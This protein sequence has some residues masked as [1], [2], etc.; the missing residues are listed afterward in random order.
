MKTEKLNTK[1]V[2]PEIVC[3]YPNLAEP[4]DEEY[5]GKYALSIPAPKSDK[6]FI[7]AINTA[8]SN[9]AVNVWGE[10]YKDLRGVKTYLVDCD[11]DP[12][13]DDDEM[14]KGCMKFSVKGKRQPGLV[15]QDGKT[16]CKQ[17]DIEDTFYP[18]A[19]I[20]VSFSAYATE[21]GGSKL[22]AFGINNVMFVKEGNRIGGGASAS[23]DFDGLG[24]DLFPED[25]DA[26]MFT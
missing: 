13:F 4:A 24:T 2:T 5:G 23:S 1:V 20:R 21:T 18:G 25:S 12:K 17:E 16:A 22:I 26:E 11:N 9:A 8:M 10:K 19:I 14:Y 6:K 15:L 3:S 7:E